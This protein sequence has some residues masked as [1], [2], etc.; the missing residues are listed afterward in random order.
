MKRPFN[1]MVVLAVIGYD[2]HIHQICS[3]KNGHASLKL[4]EDFKKR[5]G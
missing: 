5:K 1:E 4:E 3:S 2:L